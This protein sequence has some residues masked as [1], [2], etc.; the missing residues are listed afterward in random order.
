MTQQEK[1][2]LR[3]KM[4]SC[5]TQADLVRMTEDLHRHR[6]R[7]E[8]AKQI[9]GGT[10][11]RIALSPEETERVTGGVYYY[12][13]SRS[14]IRMPFHKDS[15]SM[16]TDYWYDQAAMIECMFEAGG[17]DIDAITDFIVDYYGGTFAETKDALSK[18]PFFWADSRRQTNN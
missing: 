6:L 13:E 8:E 4:E 16:G 18:G 17:Y 11:T 12:T 14:G 7:P 5:K 15:Y 10:G 9:S 2:E 3:E 1:K